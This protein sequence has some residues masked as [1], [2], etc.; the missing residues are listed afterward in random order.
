MLL[1]V[2]QVPDHDSNNSSTSTLCT[3]GTYNTGKS[4]GTVPVLVPSNLSL[5]SLRLLVYLTRN[6]YTC[7]LYL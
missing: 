1:Y 2:V 6:L 5:P 4:K 7:I 3:M